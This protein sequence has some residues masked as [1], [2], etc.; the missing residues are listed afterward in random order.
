[1]LCYTWLLGLIIYKECKPSNLILIK[2]ILKN[3]A[4]IVNVECMNVT[5]HGGGVSLI[6]L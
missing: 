2:L 6:T 1:M 5:Q 4:G 3:V